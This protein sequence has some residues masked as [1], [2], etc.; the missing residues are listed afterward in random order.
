MRD[1]LRYNR[2]YLR[3]YATMYE[4]KVYVFKRQLRIHTLVN[5]LSFLSDAY[6]LWKERYFFMTYY[7]NPLGILNVFLIELPFAFI[8]PYL[9]QVTLEKSVYQMTECKC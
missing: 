1:Q 8:V 2:I 9:V 6:V 4:R 5:I 3:H 7:F